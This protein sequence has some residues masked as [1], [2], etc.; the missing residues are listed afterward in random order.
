MI[1]VWILQHSVLI[2]EDFTQELEDIVI[3]LLA[4][5]VYNSE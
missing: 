2:K 5:L 1:L 3:G 4:L